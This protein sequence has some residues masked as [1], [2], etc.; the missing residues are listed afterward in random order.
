VWVGCLNRYVRVE[1]PITKLLVGCVVEGMNCLAVSGNGDFDEVAVLAALMA[2]N[3]YRYPQAVVVI[4]ESRMMKDLTNTIKELNAEREALNCV[5]PTISVVICLYNRLAELPID[6]S[7]ITHITML[8]AFE[9][10]EIAQVEALRDKQ[11]NNCSLLLLLSHSID[12]KAI[13][14]TIHAKFTCISETEKK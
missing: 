5:N 14:T 11:V 9:V 1:K 2:L 4:K 6:Y 13:K 12:V 3:E 10:S 7:K 8:G